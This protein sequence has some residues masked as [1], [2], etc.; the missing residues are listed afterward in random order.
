[1]ARSDELDANSKKQA[2]SSGGSARGD[3]NQKKAKKVL[4]QA[5][6]IAAAG[7]DGSAIKKSCEIRRKLVSSEIS[8][9]GSSP[10]GDINQKKA[11]KVLS[12][13]DLS[14][15][16]GGDGSAIKKSCEFKHKLLSLVISSSES[17]PRGD[18]YLEEAEKVLSRAGLSRAAGGSAA[19]DK[20]LEKS[21]ARKRG[22]DLLQKAA[23]EYCSA[24]LLTNAAQCYEKAAEILN[25]REIDYDSFTILSRAS[26][27]YEKNDQYDK[28]EQVTLKL[29]NMAT[30]ENYV[31]RIAQFNCE[32]ANICVLKQMYGEA[33]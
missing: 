10:R 16:A 31:S 3:I 12:Q 7:G 6:M 25:F 26:K 4:S 9:S 5:G 21:E 15:A 27:C 2:K 18:L 22:F 23:I 33:R 8:S 19:I 29:I 1:M 13:A 30:E 28:A 11:K 24:N 32:L 17:S 14:A 20:R